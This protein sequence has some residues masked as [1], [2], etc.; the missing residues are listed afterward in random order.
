MC[1]GDE[2]HKNNAL[3]NTGSI[4]MGPVMRIGIA[5]FDIETNIEIDI[6]GEGGGE[7]NRKKD[8]LSR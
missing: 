2:E 5:V 6:R 8:M 3:S 4:W 7:R 1:E